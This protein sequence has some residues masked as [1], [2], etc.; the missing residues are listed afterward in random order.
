MSDVAFSSARQAVA[1]PRAAWPTDVLAV[2]LFLLLGIGVVLQPYATGRDMPGDIDARFNLS[3]LEF[4]YR[5][6]VA[7]L[8]GRPANFLD[9]PFWYP[10][11][12]VTNFSDT[13]WGDAEV[14][15]L[16]R[17]LGVN[18]LASFQAWFVAGFALTYVAAFVSLR[19]LGLH[20]WGSA[21]G[22]F[23]FTFCLPMAA[24]LGHAQ[25]VY[26]LWVP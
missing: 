16:F 18:V 24:Q 23:L 14:Y 6:L 26:R 20:S 4:F 22:A 19:K 21:A 5:T 10:W 8:H 2:L 13:H 12:R 9:A 1:G 7:A 17:A 25:L 11:P 15:A 3:L